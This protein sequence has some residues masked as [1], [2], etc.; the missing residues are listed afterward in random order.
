MAQ[1]RFDE[2]IA[3]SA[4]AIE[5]DPLSAIIQIDAANSYV[6]AVRYD[7]AIEHIHKALEIDPE[8][9]DAYLSLGMALELKGDVTGAIAEFKRAGERGDRTVS[10]AFLGNL[11]GKTGNTGEAAKMLAELE[12]LANKRHV[13]AYLFA[14]LQVGLGNKVEAL[15]WL[16]KNYTD[17]SEDIANIKVD[18]LLKP[19]HGDP[20][21]EALAQKVFSK[22]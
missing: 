16:E 21:F 6:V 14:V 10:L 22:Q 5:L 17:G 9:G 2:A 3:E 13:S 19:L 4:R 1:G 7:E 8:F 15:R 18:P 20:R 11:Y 12:Q